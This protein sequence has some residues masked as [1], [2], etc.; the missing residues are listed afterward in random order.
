MACEHADCVAGGHGPHAHRVVGAAGEDV[1]GVG[2]EADAVDVLL[3]ADEDALLP[4]VVCYPE[5]GGF[6]VAA[7]CEV[8]AEG[9]PLEIPDWLVVAFVYDHA[10]P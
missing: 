6:V 9:A 2:V 1:G 10:L 7:G 8:V 5:S 3:V 4:D